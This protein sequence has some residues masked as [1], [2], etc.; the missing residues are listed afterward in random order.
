MAT[1]W[2]DAHIVAAGRLPL[3]AFLVGLLTAFLGIRVS[4]RLIRA[5]TRWWPG[6]I[7]LGGLHVHHVVFGVVF[8][9]AAGIGGL[10]VS[11]GK[12]L[13]RAAL[14]LLF[15][16]GTGLVLD[17]FALILH[18]E[19]V[20]WTERGRTSIDAVFAAVAL[21]A[22]MLTGLRPLGLYGFVPGGAAGVMGSLA[23]AVVTLLKGKHWTG[24]VG[25][26][27]P[28]LL[29][30]GALRL[31]RPKAPWSRWRYGPGKQR[32][33]HLRET[34]LREPVVAAKVRIQEL[35]AGRHD[36]ARAENPIDAGRAAVTVLERCPMRVCGDYSATA[37]SCTA[38][39]R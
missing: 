10:A 38:L 39:T 33:A 28:P 22:M 31:S 7:R 16:V 2:F 27:C 15:G 20:Y 11:D 4:V 36:L 29:I 9:V 1:P 21:S 12:P 17:E 3:F 35:L 5:G 30:V 26:F 37:R 34:R 13:W 24:L 19:D 6:N 23:L 32:R 8:M 25:L 14:A 18:L